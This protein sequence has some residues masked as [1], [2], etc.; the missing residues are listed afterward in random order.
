MLCTTAQLETKPKK[1]TNPLL[2]AKFISAKPN[3]KHKQ[4]IGHIAI[5]GT[6][7]VPQGNSV[8]ILEYIEV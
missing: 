5:A 8:I 1:P 6:L 4:I 7:R 2:L 3:T